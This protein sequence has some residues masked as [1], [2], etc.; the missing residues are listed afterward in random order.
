MR[1]A[2]VSETRNS[3]SALLARVKQGETVVITDRRRPVARLVAAVSAVNEGPDD[4][5]LA[6]LER[7]GVVRR[8]SRE[9]LD[10][11][12]RVSPPSA[13]LGADVVAALVDERRSGR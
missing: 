13:G 2:T 8:A 9:R 11:I 7:S 10:E 12:V 4:G 3:L 5:R 1:S 6:R